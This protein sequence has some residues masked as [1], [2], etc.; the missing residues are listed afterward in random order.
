ME[1]HLYNNYNLIIITIQLC[2][3]RY[4]AMPY[5]VTVATPCCI[6]NLVRK[7][8]LKS[9]SKQDKQQLTVTV[10]IIL[11]QTHLTGEL[12]ACTC[13]NRPRHGFLMLTTITVVSI[14]H[15]KYRPGWT[16]TG[17]SINN[18]VDI[19]SSTVLCYR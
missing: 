15:L 1:F 12:N 14:F 7:T 16:L 10:N 11:M 13:I 18:F 4:L 9:L 19:R 17:Y 3:Q 2:K 5:P 8:H 6:R